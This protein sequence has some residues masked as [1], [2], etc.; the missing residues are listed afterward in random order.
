MIVLTV[1]TG[2][3]SVRLSLKQCFGLDPCKAIGSVRHN[4]SDG[5]PKVLLKDFLH[6]HDINKVDIVSHRVVHGGSTLVGSRILDDK[7]VAEI[8]RLE[9]L[10]PLHNRHAVVWIHASMDVVG[11][12]VPQVGV[13]D[14]A[15]YEDLPAVASSY[16]IPCELGRRYHIRRYGFHGLAHQAMWQRWR[17]LRPDIADGGRLISLQL[18]AGCSVTAT[19]RG[20]ARDTSMGFTPSEGLM[21]ATRCGD[22]D[23][24]LVTFLQRM[25]GLTPDATDNLLEKG[26]GLLGVSGISNDIRQLIDSE[27]PDAHLAVDLFCYR[28]RKYIGA[29]MAVLGGVDG[30]IFGGGVGENVPQVRKGILEGMEWCGISLNDTS[31]TNTIGCEGR[32]SDATSKADVRVVPVDEAGVLAREAIKLIQEDIK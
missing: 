4:H 23:P 14:T 20:V 3:S 22:I 7:S 9:T 12:E 24:G 13:F 19:D 5:D 11:S 10:A 30:I 27:S 31:N 2:S 28:A 6:A 15:F 18:G 1:N 16:A 26:S 21:M 25:E 8:K 17:Q 29:Y 32:I